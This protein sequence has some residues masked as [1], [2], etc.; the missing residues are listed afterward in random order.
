[1]ILWFLVFALGVL[2]L[3][4][5]MFHRALS[6]A[7]PAR[8]EELNIE[9]GAYRSLPNLGDAVVAAAWFKIAVYA[10]FVTATSF[11]VLAERAVAAGV[12]AAAAAASVAALVA[13]E[14]LA[15]VFVGFHSGRLFYRILPLVAAFA[16]V[17]VPILAAAGVLAG[18]VAR[19]SGHEAPLGPEQAAQEDILDAVTEGAR[20]GV[21]ESQERDMIESIIE[22]KDAQVSKIMTPRTELFTVPADANVAAALETAIRSGHSRLPV[23]TG[24]ADNIVG[25]LYVKDV[26]RVAGSPLALTAL[27]TD[28]MRSPHFVPETKSIKQMLQEFR[29]TNVHM[30][31]VLDEYGGTSGIVTIEDILE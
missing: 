2:A 31:I 6:A 8:L 24:T 25:V 29:A 21:I 17:G 3:A 27:V 28:V 1:M 19:I 26:L 30:A 5:A 11:A 22:F 7:S 10:A 9:Q 15:L 13:C 12:F 23:C 4:A 18:I 16:A 14:A 20:E